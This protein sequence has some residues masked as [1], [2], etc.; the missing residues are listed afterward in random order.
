MVC[1]LDT[2]IVVKM[3]PIS[4]RYVVDVMLLLGVRDLPGYSAFRYLITKKMVTR[5][6]FSLNTYISSI[7]SILSLPSNYF[8]F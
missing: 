4:A 7:I 6:S 2:K 1:L 8:V 3:V 5:F